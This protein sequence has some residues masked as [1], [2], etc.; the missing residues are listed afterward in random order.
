MGH[1]CG[2]RIF[3]ERNLRTEQGRYQRLLPLLLGTRTLLG[4]PGLTTR[5]SWPYYLAQGRY[6][7]LLALLLGTR[8][9]LGASSWPYY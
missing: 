4:A 5:G 2:R 3:G 6:W 8:T 1:L 7:G 9:L